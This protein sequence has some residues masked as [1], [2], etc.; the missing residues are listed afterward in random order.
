MV[1]F[2]MDPALGVFV[3]N[4]SA[5]SLSRFALFHDLLHS[6]SHMIFSL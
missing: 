5:Q 6:F 3:E 1:H 4:N 2:F